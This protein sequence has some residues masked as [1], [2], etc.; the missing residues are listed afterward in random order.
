[1]YDSRTIA[2]RLIDIAREK[3][4]T[5]TPMQLIKLVYIAHGWML[6]LYHRSLIKDEVQA[7]RYGPVIPRLYNAVKGFKSQPV[8]AHIKSDDQ[9]L[10]A[11]AADLVS[12]VYER[13]GKLSGPAL[14]RLTHAKDTP[15]RLTYEP[16]TFGIA[17]S[18]DLIEDHYAQLASRAA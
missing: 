10:D 1:M 3:N 5:L 8:T 18:N 4:E 12:Q 16:N 2:N 15:W 13:Y 17:I 7:W 11:E 6:A 9:P 14:S